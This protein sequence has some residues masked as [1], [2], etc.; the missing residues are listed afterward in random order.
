MYITTPLQSFTDLSS[1]GDRKSVK[2][3]GVDGI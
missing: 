2:A 1:R 3:Q